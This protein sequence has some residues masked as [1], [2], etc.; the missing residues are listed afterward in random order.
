MSVFVGLLGALTLAACG[1]ADTSAPAP[2]VASPTAQSESPAAADPE[3]SGGRTSPAQSAVE[4][5]S[6]E[7]ANTEESSTEQSE[8]QAGGAG[9]AGSS[10]NESDC[11]IGT[12]DLAAVTGLSWQFVISQIDH[13]SEV[14]DGVLTDVCGFTAPEVVDEYG[15]PAFMRIDVYSGADVATRQEGYATTCTS[16][17]GT[18]TTGPVSGGVYCSKDGVAVDGQVGGGDRLVELWI[19]S[20]GDATARFSA[21]FDQILA[22]VN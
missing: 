9:A 6:T 20:G 14:Y 2:T 8:V 18:L 5:S 7:E 19:N 11:P 10:G 12:A 3:T 15:D 17:G 21:A 16:I 13:P 1:S 22:A 4:E